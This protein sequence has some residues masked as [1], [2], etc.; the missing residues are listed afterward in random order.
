MA[1]GGASSPGDLDLALVQYAGFAEGP[2]AAAGEPDT[3]EGDD[4][5]ARALA[6]GPVESNVVARTLS[7][8]VNEAVD[9]EA[10]GAITRDELEAQVRE[11]LGTPA[12]PFGWLEELGP[13]AVLENLRLLD[14][15]Y[16]G[17]HYRPSEAL[18]A[19]ADPDRAP[20][21]DPDRTERGLP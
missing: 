8:M 17:G 10:R 12:G 21:P 4:F 18:V 2:F 15:A 14:A 3:V 5:A 7:M 16:P 9:L 1:G 20:T 11:S 6:R 19:L 13:A